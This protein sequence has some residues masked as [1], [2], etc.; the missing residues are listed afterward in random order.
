MRIYISGPITG[1]NPAD[2]FM[3]FTNAESQLLYLGHKVYNPLTLADFLPDNFT[4]KDYM[5]VDLLVIAKCD[6]AYFMPG[7]SRS[8]GCK[9]ERRFCETHG[10]RIYDSISEVAN[11][12]Q[13]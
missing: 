3:A 13:N 5:D 10:I 9:I 11:E 12:D 4:H 8:E 2:A 6:A 7:W 1:V